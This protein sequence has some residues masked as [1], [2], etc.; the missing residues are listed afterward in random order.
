MNPEYADSNPDTLTINIDWELKRII[1]EQT[2]GEHKVLIHGPR[3]EWRD[4][5]WV[6]IQK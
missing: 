5:Q 6:K 3:F 1:I 4:G 2:T